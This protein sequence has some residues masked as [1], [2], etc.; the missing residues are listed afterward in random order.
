MT[1]D[2]IVGRAAEVARLDGALATARAGTPVVVLVTGE[3]GMGKPHLA[4]DVGSR[5]DA[6]VL[7]VSCDP[8]DADRDHG[9]V[10]RLLRAA[11][12]APGW[13]E[14]VV[15]GAGADPLEAGAQLLAALDDLPLDRGVVAVVDD[16]QWADR[17]SLDAGA[18]GPS[19]WR[20]AAAAR[21]TSSGW[22][23]SWDT[24]G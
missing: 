12:L 22:P 21:C 18:C 14:R 23:A 8:A 16:A 15:P 20:C 5:T 17:P 24:P 7:A 10:K 4:G 6:V 9:L 2:G 3:P 13:V 19:P 1:A 11:P